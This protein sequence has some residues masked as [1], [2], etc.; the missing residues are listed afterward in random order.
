MSQDAFERVLPGARK[1]NKRHILRCALECFLEHG[2][3]STTIEIIRHRAGVSVGTIYHHFGKKEGLV[4]ALF[5]AALDD[6][7]ALMWPELEKATTPRTAIEQLV[8]SYIGWVTQEPELARFMF[9]ARASVAA[10]PHGVTLML[11]NREQYAFLQTWL[12]KGV[13]LGQIRP[14]PKETYASLLVGQAENYCRA[15]L[16]GRVPTSPNDHATVF[17][18]AAWRSLATNPR[19]K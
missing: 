13:K 6:H 14:L 8:K 17:A 4:A 1:T 9:L 2:L 11:R 19:R 18:E 5:F 10:G 15:W 16:S 3:E 7:K 12:A